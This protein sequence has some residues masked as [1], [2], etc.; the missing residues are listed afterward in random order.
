M[1]GGRGTRLHPYSALLPKPLMPLGDMPVLELLLRQLRRAGIEEV[2]LAVNHLSHLIQ[3]FFGDGARFGM[4]IKYSVEDRPLGT[5]GPMAAV[6]GELGDNFILTNGDLL[7]TLNISRMIQAHS[8]FAPRATVGVYERELNIDFGLI[9][10]DHDMQLT[11]YREKPK[12]KHLVSMGIYVLNREAILEHLR[13]GQYLDMP[14]LL[15]L[16][17][18]RGGLLLA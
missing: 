18:S 14:N 3:A 8:A 7:T 4:Q 15:Q 17:L 10:T 2:Y 5:A 11:G 9:E 1:A 13:I 16:L 12:Y 6:I